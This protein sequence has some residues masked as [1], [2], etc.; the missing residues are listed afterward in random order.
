MDTKI[1]AIVT[2]FS[3]PSPI[4]VPCSTPISA[5]HWIERTP[6]REN[7]LFEG[8]AGGADPSTGGTDNP[9]RGEGPR[10]GRRQGGASRA[11]RLSSSS[12]RSAQHDEGRVL[13][14]GAVQLGSERAGRS[15]GARSEMQRRAK[16]K[17][18]TATEVDCSTT[19]DN[20]TSSKEARR[21]LVLPLTPLRSSS[22]H[23]S[24]RGSLRRAAKSLPLAH[25]NRSALKNMSGGRILLLREGGA[26]HVNAEPSPVR[27]PLQ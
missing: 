20:P 5:V 3:N 18:R 10:R 13:E 22:S 25:W 7:H 8:P 21:L 6:A 24:R 2:S 15:G 16:C 4:E 19:T 11:P 12:A 26:R 14:G 23:S 9:R 17:G 1:P 27:P